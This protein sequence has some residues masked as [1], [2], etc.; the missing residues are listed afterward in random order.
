MKGYLFLE[1]NLR[2]TKLLLFGTYHSKNLEYGLNDEDFFEQINL[3]LDVYSNYDKF[4]LVGDF[5]I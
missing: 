1:I 5:N 3:A 4:L 2:T